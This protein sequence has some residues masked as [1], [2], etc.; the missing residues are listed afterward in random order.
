MEETIGSIGL[1]DQQA[2]QHALERQN[3]LTKPVGSLGVLEDI[4][5]KLAG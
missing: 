2:M 3:S 1:L 5:V 4:A